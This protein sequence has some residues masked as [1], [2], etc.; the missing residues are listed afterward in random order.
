MILFRTDEMRPEWFDLPD[1]PEQNSPL[2]WE[3]MWI[4][5]QYWYPIMLSGKSFVGRADFKE[6][7]EEGGV[8]TYT[9]LR[10]WFGARDL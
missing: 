6:S 7:V 8:K 4:D 1:S 5:D 3:K 10:W 2:P 9:L